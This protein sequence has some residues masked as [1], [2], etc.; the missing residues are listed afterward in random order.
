MSVLCAFVAHGW[1]SDKS[2]VASA[3]RH[4]YL[5]R[6]GGIPWCIVTQSPHSFEA[7]VYYAEKTHQGHQGSESMIRRA[8]EVMYWSGMQ[9]AVLQESAKCSLYASHGSAL[10]REPM[11]S[12]EI[13]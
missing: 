11:L 8:R 7:T 1:P 9:A 13:P 2:Q 4:C 5:L 12:H 6:D 10:P 3:L